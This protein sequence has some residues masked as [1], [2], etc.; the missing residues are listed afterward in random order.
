MEGIMKVLVD[1]NMTIYGVFDPPAKIEL[2]GSRATLKELLK[3]LSDLCKSVEFIHGD[4][5]GSDV[6]TILV[7]ETE[8]YYLDT[9]INEGD[10][11]M[12]KVE[13]APLGGG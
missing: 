7:N 10:K 9:P 3:E 4:E 12:V 1:S 13:M 5:I 11:I 6:Q 2:K 8:H